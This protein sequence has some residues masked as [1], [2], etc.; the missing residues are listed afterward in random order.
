MLGLYLC[1]HKQIHMIN[2]HERKRK[3]EKLTAAEA[4]ALQK[5]VSS[6]GTAIDAAASIGIHRNTL[7]LVLIKGAGSPDTIQKIRNRL[8]LATQARA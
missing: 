3:S 6:C 2:I 5:F 7:D 8:D 1:F 4:K